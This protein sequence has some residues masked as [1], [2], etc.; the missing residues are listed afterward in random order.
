LDKVHEAN[1]LKCGILIRKHEG[2]RPLKRRVH[3]YE[4]NIKGDI[5]EMVWAGITQL[6]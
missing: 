4:D 2:K 1:D 5:E 6:V 3:S